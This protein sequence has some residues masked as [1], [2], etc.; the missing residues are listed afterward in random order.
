MGFEA[1]LRALLSKCNNTTDMIG[2]LGRFILLCI[3]CSY[4]FFVVFK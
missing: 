4:Y 1:K 2:Q 3:S